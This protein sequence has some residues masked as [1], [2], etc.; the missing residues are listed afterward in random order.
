MDEQEAL[1]TQVTELKWRAEKAEGELGDA[2]AEHSRSSHTQGLVE[3]EL[4]KL[5]GQVQREHGEL[6]ELQH[7]QINKEK[8]LREWKKRGQA[9]E[10]E[11]RELK[12]QVEQEHAEL[13]AMQET[14][15]AE[16]FKSKEL[17]R[18][19]AS[20]EEQLQQAKTQIAELLRSQNVAILEKN[21]Q[22]GEVKTVKSANP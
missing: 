1:V 10:K 21:Q 3:E 18:Q 4:E 17:E 2:L 7:A 16:T 5:K 19:T 12:G 6:T 20:L 8:E 22:I 9:A 13:L 15:L 11:L 14:C